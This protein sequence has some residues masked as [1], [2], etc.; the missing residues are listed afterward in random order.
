MS[1]RI[2]ADAVLVLHLAFI[3]FATLGGL[4]VLRWPRLAW[5]H[6]P[7]MLWAAGITFAGGIC[8]LTPL[9]NR[10]RLVGGETGYQGSFIEHYLTSIIY[11]AGLTR[12]TQ[13]ALGVLLLAFNAAVYLRFFRKRG[14]SAS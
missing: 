4:A 10:L 9:E 7:V 14:A 12:S 6:L 11:P 5:L 1:A 3:A 13:V 8:P 2:L